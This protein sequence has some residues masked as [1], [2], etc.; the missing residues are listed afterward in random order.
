M[1]LLFPI[2]ALGS[3]LFMMVADRPPNFDT[4]RTCKADLSAAFGEDSGDRYKS[5]MQDEQ[6]AHQQVQTLWPKVPG[7]ARESCASQE[8]IGDTPSFVSLLTCLEMANAK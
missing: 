3:Q 4:S 1:S 6:T 2:A 8:R 7:P 5:C